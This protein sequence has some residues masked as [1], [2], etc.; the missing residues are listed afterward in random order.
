MKELDR[1][2]AA[3]THS[4]LAIKMLRLGRPAGLGVAVNAAVAAT[5]AVI[6]ASEEDQSDVLNRITGRRWS[7]SR[8]LGALGWQGM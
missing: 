6:A 1:E 2:I 4:A 5:K 8:W 3:S 7:T